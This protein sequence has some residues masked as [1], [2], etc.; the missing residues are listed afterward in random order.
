MNP[1]RFSRGLAGIF[2]LLAARTVCAVEPQ[3]VWWFNQPSTQIVDSSIPTNNKGPANLGQ[4]K[5]VAMQAKNYFDFVLPGGAG[6]T[7]NSM[8]AAFKPQAGVSYTAAELAQ[9]R[10]DNYSPLKLGQL[11]NVAKAFYD[12]L[13]QSGYNTTQNLIDHGYPLSWTSRYPW[14]DVTR[15]PTAQNYVP[16]SV[17]QLKMV[18]S[19]GYADDLDGDGIRDSVEIANG[20]NPY[21]VDTDHDGV[22]DGQDAFPLDPTRGISPPNDPSDH[23]APVISLSKPSGA[24]LTP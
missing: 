12:R 8:V 21:L 19:F 4:L 13:Y 5:N 14:D 17:G 7:I 24:I 10:I 20:T 18:F 1:F 22:R 2:I 16:V 11:K 9:I 3:P 6:T 15:I 23:T